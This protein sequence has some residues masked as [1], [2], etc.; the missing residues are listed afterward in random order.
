MKPTN[1]NRGRNLGF[2]LLIAVIAMALMYTLLGTSES[3]KLEYSELK[4]LFVEKKV[5]SFVLED[6][7]L[8]I[9]L[10]EEDEDGRTTITQKV[11]SVTWFRED[12]GEIIDEQIESEIPSSLVVVWLQIAITSFLPQMRLSA[13]CRAQGHS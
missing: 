11:P 6:N 2:Y 8:T 12:L 4:Q 9:E 5:K 7:K 13:L 3:K 1:N 10:K